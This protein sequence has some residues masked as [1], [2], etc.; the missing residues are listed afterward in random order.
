MKGKSEKKHTGLGER[1]T[2]FYIRRIKRWMVCPACRDGEMTMNKK[3]G[4]WE[5]KHCGY[6]LSAEEFKDGYSFWFCDDCDSYLN[7]QEGFDAHASKH[8]CRNCGYENDTTD[9]NL[10]GTCSDCGRILPEPEATRCADCKQARREKAKK[11]L[12]TA[13]KVVGVVA[14]AAAGA[15]YLATREKNDDQYAEASGLP[16]EGDGGD[17]DDEVYGLG[18]GNFPT[19]KTCGATMTRFDGWACYTCPE[20]EDRVRIIDG[21]ETWKGEIFGYGIYGKGK[22]QHYSDFE[23]ADFCR[24]GDLTED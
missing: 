3:A 6:T 5:C 11:W 20:C 4:H 17:D 1:L 2:Y 14:V 16:D 22:K 15:I 7:N 21:T 19:C 23:L 10:K 13:G 12:K 9:G 24:G 8:I 18:D